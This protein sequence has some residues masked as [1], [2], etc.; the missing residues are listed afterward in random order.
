[1]SEAPPAFAQATLKF[2]IG[3][4]NEYRFYDDQWRIDRS[5]KDEPLDVSVRFRATE[6]IM[7]EIAD[8]L[9]EGPES[10]SVLED[11]MLNEMAAAVFASN[12]RAK[13]GLELD[14]TLKI[15]LQIFRGEVVEYSER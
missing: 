6:G 15:C 1:M 8:M 13:C 3:M 5:V 11:V 4:S 7:K 9:E 14:E 2:T 12:E 10:A